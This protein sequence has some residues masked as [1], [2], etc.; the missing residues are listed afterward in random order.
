M[1]GWGGTGVFTVVVGHAVLSF[2]AWGFW[3]S[4]SRMNEK[5]RRWHGKGGQDDRPDAAQHPPRLDWLGSPDR[6]RRV[7]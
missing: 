5:I 4:R 7:L 2:A 1:G 6:V 3:F